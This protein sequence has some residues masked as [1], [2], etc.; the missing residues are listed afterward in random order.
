MPGKPYGGGSVPLEARTASLF[1][2]MLGEP[3]SSR[4]SSASP[5]PIR[6]GQVEV[7]PDQLSFPGEETTILV[8]PTSDPH[9]PVGHRLMRAYSAWERL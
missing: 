3:S 6:M 1:E 8:R 5:A 4:G 2:T 7:A 9:V